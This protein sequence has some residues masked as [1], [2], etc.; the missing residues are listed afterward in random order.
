MAALPFSRH[1]LFLSQKKNTHGVSTHL[2]IQS[3]IPIPKISNSNRVAFTSSFST[4]TL[5]PS[6]DGVRPLTA[7]K[8]KPTGRPRSW[9]RRRRRCSGGGGGG[10]VGGG[11]SDSTM[12]RGSERA[13]S[14]RE[15]EGGVAEEHGEGCGKPNWWWWW[16]AQSTSRGDTVV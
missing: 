9:C 5:L 12:G 4:S 14:P 3:F 16:W 13:C 6:I 15:S 2:N 1:L 11:G 8:W 10:V 7:P